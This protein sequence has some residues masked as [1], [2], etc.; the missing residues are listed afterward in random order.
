MNRGKYI[1]GCLC[2]KVRFEITGDIRDIVFCHCSRCRKAQGSAYAANGNVDINRFNFIQ[3]EGELTGYQSS[4][5]EKKYFCKNCGSP[6]L[7]K[8]K[9]KPDKVRIRLGTLE[10]DIAEHPVGHIFV[11]SK[12]N[13]E[14][15]DGKLLQYEEYEPSRKKL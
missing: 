10:T 15:I 14:D 8:N 6:I 3:G 12:A 11:G 4:P 5:M 7:S 9:S 2:G 13:W 1:G